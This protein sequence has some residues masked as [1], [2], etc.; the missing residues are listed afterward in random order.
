MSNKPYD[1]LKEAEKSFLASMRKAGKA[2]KRGGR[3][4]KDA[5]IV[6]AL[7]D[8]STAFFKRILSDEM[9]EKLWYYFIDGR[10]PEL[11]DNGIHM[12]DDKGNL[13][14]REISGVSYNAFRQM[15]AYKRGMPAVK[16][17]SDPNA[18]QITVNFNVMGTSTKD[19]ENRVREL[20]L[21]PTLNP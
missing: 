2:T 18:G 6:R 3:P 7:K 10:F 1:K 19:M 8:N 17:D 21:V 16:I 14:Y 15:V 11:D 12:K 13:M 20:G 5:L 9:E 4:S